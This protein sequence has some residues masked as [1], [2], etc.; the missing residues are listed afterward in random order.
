MFSVY[1]PDTMFVKERGKCFVAILLADLCDV[2]R[3]NFVVFTSE[4]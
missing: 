1:L 2:T 3:P 4:Q